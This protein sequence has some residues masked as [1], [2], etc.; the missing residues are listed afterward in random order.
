MQFEVGRVISSGPPWDILVA[1]GWVGHVDPGD[2]GALRQRRTHVFRIRNGRVAY[3]H[4]HE[5]TEKVA[6]PRASR[7][8]RWGPRSDLAS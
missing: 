3:F 8:R 5:D 1:A 4:A 2:R 7:W 6:P